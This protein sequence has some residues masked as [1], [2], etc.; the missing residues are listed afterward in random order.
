M[1]HAAS[2]FRQ[3]LAATAFTNPHTPVIG[4]VSASPLTNND[5]IRAELEA[6]LTSP[7]R[8][9]ESVRAMLQA[10][11]KTF[12]ELGSKDVLTGL[13]RRIDRTAQGIALDTPEGFASI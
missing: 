13:L 1:E 3:A 5:A 6:Q 9:T 12:L 8:W 11:V 10:G 2:D 7:L 4:N